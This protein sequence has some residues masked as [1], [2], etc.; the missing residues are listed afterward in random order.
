MNIPEILNA[1]KTSF[2]A[3]RDIRTCYDYIAMIREGTK[4]EKSVKTAIAHGR[5]LSDY[6][7]RL[8]PRLCDVELMR[9]FFK[10]HEELLYTLAPYDFDSYCLYLEWDRVPEQKFYAPRRRQLKPLAIQLQRLYDDELDLLCISLPP[11]IGKSTLAFFFLTWWGGKVPDKS[12]LT[13][14]HNAAFIKGAYEQILKIVGKDSE[15]RF[16]KVFP[17]TPVVNT[18]AKNYLIDLQ[19]EKRFGTFSF[20]TIGAGNAGRVR[21]QSLLY[22]DDLISGMDVALSEDRLQSLWGTYTGDLLQRKIGRCKELHI[23]TR[24]SVRDIIGRLYDRYGEDDRAE[25]IEVDCYDA[26]GNSNFDYPY[27]LG[28][29]TEALQ[30]LEQDMDEATFSALYRNRPI[31]REGQLYAEVELRRYFELPENEP[32]AIIAICDTKDKGK[33]FEFMPVAYQYGNDYYLEDCVCN[34]GKPETV[35]AMLVNLLMKHKVQMC[36]F[37]SNSAG[38]RIAEKIQGAVKERGG[39]TKITT[40]YTTTNKETKIIV[41]SPWVKE[42][43]LF[44]DKSVV[45]NNREYKRMLSFLTS[46]TLKGKNAH[47]DVPDGM[48][49]LALY[50]QSLTSN[51][52]EVFK[53]PF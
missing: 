10:A 43:V 21:A 37:E 3:N 49:M 47:D 39:R 32:D 42:H 30:R 22:C 16:L 33:D 45:G 38:G 44:K 28:Y 19:T 17:T 50:A 31:E 1:I 24:W 46:Y 36:Q 53:R 48:A 29:T 11:G 14:S 15:Y 40:K 34:D 4:N 20:S 7:D 12:M 52:I 5:W 2:K 25:F 9:D 18:D 23:A 51:N 6:L 13:V 35:E 27:N 41:N 26:D 8:V